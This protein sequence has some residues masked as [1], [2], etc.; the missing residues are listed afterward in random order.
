MGYLGIT[1]AVLKREGSVIVSTGNKCVIKWQEPSNRKRI[2]YYLVTLQGR[3]YTKIYRLKQY[4][5]DY[6]IKNLNNINKWKG[7][8][9][10]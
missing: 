2:Y 4:E 1:G 9:K 6:W 5:I 7:K 10:W 8:E 3:K